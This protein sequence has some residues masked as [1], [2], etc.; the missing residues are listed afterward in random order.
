M[1]LVPADWVDVRAH[2]A[3]QVDDRSIRAPRSTQ[4]N[5]RE[6]RF[7]REPAVIEHK[8]A[9]LIRNVFPLRREVATGSVR[10][11]VYLTVLEHGVAIAIDEIHIPRDHAVRE[12]TSRGNRRA[13]HTRSGLRTR[14]ERRG[15]G[16]WSAKAACLPT[17][18]RTD[19]Q[20]VL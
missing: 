12:I 6:A 11:T 18:P 9:L 4:I 20:R 8:R 17:S 5:V 15:V 2:D 19:I 13:R 7:A 14:R 1:P 10:R 16:R 3:V